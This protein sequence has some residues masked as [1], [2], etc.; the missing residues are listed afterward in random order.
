MKEYKLT[1]TFYTDRTEDQ[2]IE[3]MEMRIKKLGLKNMIN[4][5]RL[6]NI[7]LEVKETESI[8]II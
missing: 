1:Y 6:P 2:T 8:T 5:K 4:N 7:K 3:F